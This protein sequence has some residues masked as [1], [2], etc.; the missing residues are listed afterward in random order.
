[1]RREMPAFDRAPVASLFS[2]DTRDAITDYTMPS[3][4]PKMFMHLIPCDAAFL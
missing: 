2:R 4:E 3:M 1:M